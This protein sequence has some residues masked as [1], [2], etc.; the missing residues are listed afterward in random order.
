MSAH[1][2]PGQ[3][4]YERSSHADSA[5]QTSVP[6]YEFFLNPHFVSKAKKWRFCL[7]LKKVAKAAAMYWLASGLM[8]VLAGKSACYSL[9]RAEI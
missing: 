7:F 3:C 9:P 8:V 5:A 2:E 4:D 1:T 6:F